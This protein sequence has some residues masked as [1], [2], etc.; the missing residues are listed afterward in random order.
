MEGNIGFVTIWSEA[1]SGEQ[2]ARDMMGVPEPDSPNLISR[3][4]TCVPV[5]PGVFINSGVQCLHLS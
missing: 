5:N 1:C 3:W 2:L 4:D